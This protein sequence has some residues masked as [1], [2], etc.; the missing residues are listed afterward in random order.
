MSLSSLTFVNFDRVSHIV[1]HEAAEELDRQGLIRHDGWSA[2]KP[3]HY[4][5]RVRI[6]HGPYN[7]AGWLRNEVEE[8]LRTA[9]RVAPSYW[10][11][12][13]SRKPVTSVELVYQRKGPAETQATNARRCG[14]VAEVVPCVLMPVDKVR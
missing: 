10:R 2:P 4:V 3:S 6:G 7:K 14:L 13:S 8:V 9:M 1:G 11:Y 5:L 12:G